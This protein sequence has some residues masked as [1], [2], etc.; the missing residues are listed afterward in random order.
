MFRLIATALMLIGLLVVP[1]Q[2][3]STLSSIVP[4]DGS[5]VTAP[6]TLTMTF[7]HELHLV[8]VKLTT[9]TA[10]DIALPVDHKGAPAKTYSLTLPKLSAGTYTVRWTASASDGHVMKG[11]SSFTVAEAKP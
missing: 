7:S 1:A 2:A 3:H 10:D 4:A 6:K 9:E 8:T 5:T 11:T